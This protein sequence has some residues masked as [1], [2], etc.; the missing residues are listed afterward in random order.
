M[1][2]LTADVQSTRRV[3][4]PVSILI[5]GRVLRF[6]LPYWKGLSVTAIAI[7]ATAAFAIATPWLLRWAIDT[8]ISEVSR[9]RAQIGSIQNRLE[10]SISNLASARVNTTSAES[11]IRD[12]DIAMAVA[13]KTRDDILLQAGVSVLTQA[14]QNPALALALL[15]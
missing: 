4:V 3:R 10:V 6:A 2:A 12:A 8:A 1:T 9:E 5:I 11:R 7:L 15:T 14:N 13:Q